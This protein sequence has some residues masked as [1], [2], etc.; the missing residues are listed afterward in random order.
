MKHIGHALG[1]VVDIALEIHQGRPLLQHPVPVALGHRVG[2]GLHIGVTLS[3]VHIVPDTDDI[4]H[5]GDHIGGLP[6]GLAVGDLALALVQV[7][8]LQ[9]QQ[10]A[11]AGEGEAG[12]GGVVPEEGDAQAGI[13]DPRGNVPL[14][15]IPQRVRHGKHPGDLLVRLVPSEEK[16]V[17]V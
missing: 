11:G 3:D 7:L 4:G 14:P 2:Y 16:V 6:H 17:F 15:Q 9:A 5:E 10:V 13:K 8:D 12:P 1:G